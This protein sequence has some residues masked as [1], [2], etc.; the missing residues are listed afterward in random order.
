MDIELKKV[1]QLIPEN[2][3]I[4][5]FNAQFVIISSTTTAYLTDNYGKIKDCKELESN[6]IGKCTK[7]GAVYRMFERP[8][9][10]IPI[11]SPCS[12]Y[13]D[14]DQSRPISISANPMEE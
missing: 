4:N 13:S 7:C 1:A 11:T 12:S 3:C 14:I 6:S 5:C 8:N 9:G 2:L 10:F